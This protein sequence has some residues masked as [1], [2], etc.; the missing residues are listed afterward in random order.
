MPRATA[1]AGSGK[2]EAEQQDAAQFR[3][4]QAATVARQ[5]HATLEPDGEQQQGAHEVVDGRRQAQV[6]AC[7]AR[8]QAEDEEPDHWIQ[9]WACRAEPP[10][11]CAT[12]C[13]SP[14]GVTEAVAKIPRSTPR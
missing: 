1:Y 4:R 10:G 6:G 12:V 13:E 7:H 2:Q 3:Q 9:G 8:N 11:R 14:A 5:F